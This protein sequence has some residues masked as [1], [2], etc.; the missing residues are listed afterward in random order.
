M[1]TTPGPAPQPTTPNPWTIAR[2]Q[3]ALTNPVLIRRFLL[4]ISHA[5]GNRVMEVFTAWQCV[6]A[7]IEANAYGGPGVGGAAAPHSGQQLH[8]TD[9]LHGETRPTLPETE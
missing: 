2:I 5:P 3:N 9:D 4:D 6:A 7:N 1:T 8:A